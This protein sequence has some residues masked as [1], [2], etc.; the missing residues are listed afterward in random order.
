MNQDDG[1]W[2][3]PGSLKA[4]AL[5]VS[6]LSSRL[7]ALL[8]LI[9]VLFCPTTLA[10]QSQMVRA[11]I[12]FARP[13][14][15]L[16]YE[17]NRVIS[18]SGQDRLTKYTY[19]FA[20]V[21]GDETDE[22]L[23]TYTRFT[24]TGTFSCG[25]V[26]CTDPRDATWLYDFKGEL[27]GTRIWSCRLMDVCGGSGCEA[28]ISKHWKDTLILEIVETTPEFS[29]RS[30]RIVAATG[31]GVDQ[32][33]SWSDVHL[34]PLAALDVNRD[35]S[36]ELLFSRSAKPD[37][38]VRRGI[39]AYD[40]SADCEVW[41]YPTAD[42]V[43]PGN[44][45]V[46]LDSAGNAVLAF[47]TNS[48][49]NSYSDNNMDSHHSYAIGL[50]L[51]GQELWRSTIGGSRYYPISTLFDAND[52]GREELCV[53]A[54]PREREASC[55]PVLEA[56][57]VFSGDV[58][59]SRESQTGDTPG[60]VN[61]IHDL[62]SGNTLLALVML[63]DTIA[64]L[65]LLDSHFRLT[66]AVVGPFRGLIAQMPIV[67]R[68]EIGIAAILSDG[69][70]AILDSRLRL[71]ATGQFQGAIDFY[72]R[73]SSTLLVANDHSR[74]YAIFEVRKRP[75]LSVMFSR[76]RWWLAV[77]AAALVATAGYRTTRWVYQLYLSSAGLPSLDRMDAAVITLNPKGKILYVNNNAL[78]KMLVGGEGFTR[79]R[80]ENTGIAALPDLAA[81]IRQSYENQH[82]PVEG[83][84]TLAREEDR[85]TLDVVIYPRIDAR[86]SFR[87]KIVV[88]EDV[89]RKV[90]W[91]RK[92]VL[93]DAAQRW[94][95]KLK[96]N[97]ATARLCLDNLSEDAQ[98]GPVVA[99]NTALSEYLELVRSQ[100]T[101]SAETAEKILR[102]SRIARPER[103]P[104]DINGLIISAL[105]PYLTRLSTDRKIKTDLQHGLPLLNLDPEQ[106]LEAID[107]LL[108]NAL[109]AAGDQGKILVSTR[110]AGVL[111][112]RSESHGLQ[113]AV[114]DS[115][116]GVRPE[117]IEKI[118]E[119]GFSKFAGGTGVGLAVVRE[120][121]EN[122]GGSVT[123]E[124]NSD[125]G[126][127]FTIGLPLCG[128]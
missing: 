113:I 118:F 79:R 55:R 117:D 82:L 25:L 21:T 71:L 85:R 65:G 89:S 83:R 104:C 15:Q 41:F 60:G 100:I 3:E 75:L 102:F 37:S 112:G 101:L 8:L 10:N 4:T 61:V 28:L 34:N 49:A 1:I 35:G 9:P 125:G 22:F 109:K 88:V 68:A 5:A 54:D 103:V 114:S 7:R 59:R 18:K 43:S 44:F 39:V 72:R 106:I 23:Y 14:D 70:I 36:R 128:E 13:A 69:R 87:G 26:C 57:D 115:G 48:S 66:S 58:V 47:V 107:N 42:L 91:Q 119:P 123:V 111:L 51:T 78:V 31:N 122:H 19:H 90:G 12:D 63:Q 127:K 97:M 86:R 98:V 84:I 94:L 126:A 16:T 64:T 120:I 2:K 17:L 45:H 67:D 33:V 29:Y 99:D 76:Y 27:A 77:L 24:G 52:D 32:A 46:I 74:G 20:D 6:S 121:V 50:S 110:L 11:R 53:I 93:G 80:F 62:A 96:G 81:L 92:A 108:S 38:S 95:H 40:L 30:R 124:R 73:Q 105:Q 56:I 116:R